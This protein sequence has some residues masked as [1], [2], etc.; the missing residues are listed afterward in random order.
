VAGAVARNIAANAA[1]TAWVT[2]VMLAT[3]PLYLHLLGAEAYGLVGLFA[4]LSATMA[5]FD[6]GLSATL[7]RELARL[8]ATSDVAA[9]R[10]FLRTVEVLFLLVCLV[11]SSLLLA[12][13]GLIA[14]RWLNVEQMT[15]FDAAR[16]V[17]WMALAVA[18]Q[19]LA[20]LYL[21][22]LMARQDQ[23]RAALISAG[24]A[25]L[26]P[27]C[28]VAGILAL[29]VGV[30][31]VFAAYALV[32]ALQA[33]VTARSLWRALLCPGHRPRVAPARFRATW[34]FAAGA[35]GA[36]ALGVVLTNLDKIIIGRLLPLD[37]LGFYSLAWALA[38]GTTRLCGPIFNASYPRLTHLLMTGAAQ[39]IARFYHLAS[40]TV[41]VAVAPLTALLIF[42][43]RDILWLWTQGPASAAEA[44]GALP[45]LA[46][47]SL[48]N[49]LMHL[50][51][52]LQLA[53]G[54]TRL[55]F[56]A[57]VVGICTLVALLPVLTATYGLEGAA[58][59]WFL[60]NLGYL[61]ICIS[62]MHRRILSAE[63][64]PWYAH[65]VF[66]PVATI[67]VVSALF[68]VLG[69]DLDR[70]VGTFLAILAVT[71]LAATG[72]AVAATRDLRVAAVAWWRGRT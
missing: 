46:A 58:G 6:L 4:A 31:W 39:D 68:R 51:Y 61:A 60:L 11:L 13:S 55:A 63:L 2:V 12:G 7:F 66:L 49:A 27:A 33:L 21:T 26:K 65:S 23:V 20:S 22:G 36:N 44:A 28:A 54:W 35:G 72:A 42:W 47:G 19:M 1:A 10:D 69:P 24:F 70:G 3:A 5:L 67:A 48:F 30:W 43:P 15:V 9:G 59:G 38:S 37:Q 62:I 25:T 8:S 41:T 14:G 64:A 52:A 40:Q 34:W 29:G 53:M 57:N 71:W 50:P 17:R 18:A 56:M 16:S 45:W 32:S